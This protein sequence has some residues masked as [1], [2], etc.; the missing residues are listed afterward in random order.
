MI[1]EMLSILVAVGI[2]QKPSVKEKDE[3]TGWQRVFRQMAEEYR[4]GPAEE[5]EATYELHTAPVLRWN[6]PVRGGDDGAV[7]VWQRNGRPEI[8]GTIFAWPHADGYRVVV[9][10]MHSLSSIPLA[11]K[12]QGQPIWKIDKPSVEMKAIPEAPAP[13]KSEAARLTQMRALARDF[14]ARSIDRQESEWELRLLAQP[15]YRYDIKKP[16]D[17]LDGALFAFAQGT[18]PEVILILEARREKEEFLWEYG[19]GRF[20]DLKLH[21]KLKNKEVWSVSNSKFN[22]STEPYFARDVAKLKSP[23]EYRAPEKASPRP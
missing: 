10:E 21:V 16:G 4:L 13:S 1:A 22:Q 23:E 20:S 11:G 7:F 2:A 19:L 15:L 3:D 5:G 9:H 12:Y 17:V 14:S 8:I 6:Q 18:D